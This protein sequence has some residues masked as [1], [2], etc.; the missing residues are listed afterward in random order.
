MIRVVKINIAAYC[1]VS[2]EKEDQLNS[3]ETQKQFFTE[4]ANHNNHNLVKIYADEGISGTKIKNRKEFLKLMKDSHQNLFDMVVVKDISRFARNTVDFLQSIRTLKSLNIETVFLTAN[5]TV[6]GNSEFILTVFSALAQE[7]SANTSKRIKF[8]KKMNA[9]KGRVP[10]FVYGYD[11]TIGDYFNLNINEKESEVVKK[12]FN[13]YVIEG[14][15]ANKIANKLNENKLNTKRGCLWTQHTIT[16]ILKNRIYIG[17]IINGKQSIKDFLT[18]DRETHEE[19][20]WIKIYNENL[21]II[22]HD[23]FYKA[24]DILENRNKIFNITKERNSNKHLFSKLIKC[25]YCNYS[26]RRIC[27]T[28]KNTHI[29]WTCSGRN[30]N[31][32]GSCPNKT[33]I[34]EE[35]LIVDITS[36]ITSIVKD[37]DL[38]KRKMMKKYDQLYASKLQSTSQIDLKNELNKL[39]KRRQK[40]INMYDD[41]LISRDEL[42]EKMGAINT[43]IQIKESEIKL[44]ESEIISKEELS[45]VFDS[46]IEDMENILNSKV[47]T[48]EKLKKIIDVIYVDENTLVKINYHIYNLIKKF[49]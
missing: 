40:L 38:I 27:K 41:D 33:I 7:E 6:L 32:T 18:G 35:D 28:Y 43:E 20:D 45:K 1:R 25:T 30:Q 37:K 23:I 11:K 14:I 13:M 47:Y 12:I 42:K 3:L 49:I 22:D 19:E 17:E 21:A 4:Y 31:G 48:N 8:G 5:Q 16:R 10:N 39:N 24:Q 29:Y 36:G 26:F 15:G 46:C 2:T 44:L 9:K 34:H